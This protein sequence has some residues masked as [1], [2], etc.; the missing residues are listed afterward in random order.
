ME[1]LTTTFGEAFGDCETYTEARTDAGYL[2]QLLGSEQFVALTVWRDRATGNR[3]SG[4]LPVGIP[5]QLR[6]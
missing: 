4:M 5:F 1:A 6:S 2:E 3:V